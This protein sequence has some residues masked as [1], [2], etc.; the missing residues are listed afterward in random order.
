[1]P[2]IQKTLADTSGFVPEI[3]ANKALE[4]LRANCV[5]ARLI[6]KDSDMSDSFSVGDTL[7]IP[8]P[9]TFV[10]QNKAADTPVTLQVPTGGTTI[11]VDLNQHKEVSFLVEDAASAQ[12]NPEILERYIDAAVVPLAEAIEGDILAL[13]TG[14]IATTGT[15]GTDITAATIRAARKALNDAKVPTSRRHLVVSSKDDAALLADSALQTYFANAR[16]ETIEQG[17]LGRLYGFDL[18]MSQ[19]VKVVTGTPNS[20]KN[21]AFRWDAFILAMRRMK[22]PPAGTG[23]KVATV[24]DPHS[25]LMIRVLWGYNMSHL[26]TQVTLDVLYGVKTLRAEKGVI[27]LS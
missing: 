27:V 23:V 15:S 6:A 14:I 13:H 16:P 4:V 8:Y 19:L 3:W 26:G 7:R 10:A 9:G 22:E 20:T 21:L 25:G 1:M 18:W 5:M 12:A 2:N 24:R 11:T 17:S